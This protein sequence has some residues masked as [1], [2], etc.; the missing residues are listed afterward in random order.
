MISQSNILDVTALDPRDKHPAIFDRFDA[1]ADGETLTISNDHDPKPLYYQMLAERGKIFEWHYI[2]KGPLTWLVE[3][4]KT[5]H[6][7][8][9]ETIGTICAADMRKAEVFRKHGIDFCCGGKKTL[10]EACR[11]NGLDI[12]AIKTELENAGTEHYET[13]NT[14]MEWDPSF[15][16]DYIVQN[17]HRYIEKQIPVLLELSGKSIA[18]HGSAHSELR[19]IDFRLR[20]LLSE[21][22]AHMHKEEKV[23]FP[24]IKYMEQCLKSRIKPDKPVFDTVEMPINM[25]EM[26]HE[27]AGD[28]LSDINI[29]SNSYTPPA[30]ACNTFK[31]LYTQLSAFENDLKTHIHLENNILFPKSL[32]LERNLEK[33]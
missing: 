2:E 28:L 16:A 22:E 5:L 7:G 6:S 27:S 3:I 33:I 11:E 17:H 12:L 4:K 10:S 26:E 13:V 31:L 29:L 15:L 20:T 9:E 8:H 19:E 24:Y 1:L 32:E 23:L 14:Y 30:D 18:A 21:L 25:M